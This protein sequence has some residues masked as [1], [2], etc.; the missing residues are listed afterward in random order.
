MPLKFRQQLRALKEFENCI[1]IARASLRYVVIKVCLLILSLLLHTHDTNA[2]ISSFNILICKNIE[3][4]SCNFCTKSLLA[5]NPCFGFLSAVLLPIH[6][7]EMQSRH[8]RVITD[9]ISIRKTL[10]IIILHILGLL[11]NSYFLKVIGGD[12][13][14][15]QVPARFIVCSKGNLSEPLSANEVIILK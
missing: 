10:F 2:N 7:K 8:T 1:N 15:S 5:S 12:D 13:P 14:P 6:R 4:F 3:V 9:A 11:K